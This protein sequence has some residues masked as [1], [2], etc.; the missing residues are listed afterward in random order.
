MDYRLHYRHTL[1]PSPLLVFGPKSHPINKTFIQWIN[2]F[3]ASG[4]GNTIAFTARHGVRWF[5]WMWMLLYKLQQRGDMTYVQTATYWRVL[6]ARR[7]LRS[8]WW[9]TPLNLWERKLPPR[10]ATHQLFFERW[11]RALFIHCSKFVTSN[12]QGLFPGSISEFEPSLLM[13]HVYLR[14]VLCSS[15]I[16]SLLL[17]RISPSSNNLPGTSLYLKNCKALGRT[18]FHRRIFYAAAIPSL[19]EFAFLIICYEGLLFH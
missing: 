1:F 12:S 19:W 15:I 18:K 17:S 14:Y 2:Q 8:T 11:E 3:D 13:T 10:R 5:R 7:T 6:C 16:A 9:S 4:N